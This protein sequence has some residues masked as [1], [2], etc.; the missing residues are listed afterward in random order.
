MTGVRPPNRPHDA[1]DETTDEEW[2][3]QVEL[4]HRMNMAGALPVTF[5]NE[6]EI[7][8]NGPFEYT[9]AQR[10]AIRS[11]TE[12][13]STRLLN[14][15]REE[16]GGTYGI[17]A[18]Q[19]YQKIPRPEYTITID[20]GCDPKRT[21]D[22]IKRVFDEIDKFKA[23]GP[24]EKELTDEREALL[25]E[26]DTNMKQN[27]YLIGQLK[28]KY[29]YGEDPSTLWSVPDVYRKLDAATVQQAAKT[30]LTTSSYV[31]VVLM[32]EKK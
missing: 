32:P 12:I 17:S 3:Q 30:Y 21:D 24:T 14:T 8:M 10:T 13:L 15:I 27:S 4:I 9:Q 29:Q 2:Q 18:S 16:L 6:I 7:V 5:G 31:Q 19:G 28:L 1:A 26:F 11:M 25:K 22:L 20:F 23:S